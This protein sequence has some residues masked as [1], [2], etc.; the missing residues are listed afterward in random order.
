MIGKFF[1]RVIKELTPADTS[2][3]TFNATGNY[4]PRYGKQRIYVSGKGGS[5]TYTAGNQ[6][7]NSYTN[8]GTY[9]P[10]SP[11]D[12]SYTNAGT[13]T[14]STTNPPIAV[15]GPPSTGIEGSEFYANGAIY[16]TYA[17][18][19]PDG[20]GNY[21]GR[22]WSAYNPGYTQYM[23]YSW[24]NNYM[25]HQSPYVATTSPGYYTAYNVTVPAPYTVP[26]VSSPQF[27]RYINYSIPGNPTGNYTPGNTNTA[28]YT[29]GNYVAGNSGTYSP[30]YTAGNYVAGNSGTYAATVNT[31]SGTTVFG[32]SLPGGYGGAASVIPA[33]VGS[34]PTYSTT[35]ISITVPSGGYVTITFTV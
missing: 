22:K 9:T 35:P 23:T 8:S 3:V 29:P 19:G 16:T 30:T 10:G 21:V 15:I 33:T 25:P 20:W 2:P 34:I 5:G 7:D 13:Y 18:M 26:A 31:G 28:T 6:F 24:S 27:V 17:D 12:N 14:A 4:N 32:V 1:S 11:F